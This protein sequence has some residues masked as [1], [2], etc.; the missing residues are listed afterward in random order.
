MF[1]FC[2]STTV[3]LFAR[4]RGTFHS[5]V[6]RLTFKSHRC[7][8]GQK[9]LALDCLVDW[10]PLS[11]EM[12]CL[13]ELWLTSEIRGRYNPRHPLSTAA[14]FL[15]RRVTWDIGWKP[16]ALTSSLEIRWSSNGVCKHPDSDVSKEVLDRSQDSG[17]GSFFSPCV[18]GVLFGD[19]K[20]FWKTIRLIQSKISHFSR[21]R[22]ICGDYLWSKTDGRYWENIIKN[23]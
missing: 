6:L 5:K 7:S 21:L 20:P 8:W 9:T 10:P 2:L 4:V 14:Q 22:M 23:L 16:M 13:E 15:S 19:L 3:Q 18:K 11:Y 12:L 17:F 1:H